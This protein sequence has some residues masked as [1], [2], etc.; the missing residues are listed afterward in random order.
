VVV[1][2]VCLAEKN[3]N[4]TVGVKYND[5]EVPFCRCPHCASEFQDRLVGKI[6]YG[7]LFNNLCC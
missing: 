6:E 3:I 5:I 2:P 7:G 1:C 4:Q